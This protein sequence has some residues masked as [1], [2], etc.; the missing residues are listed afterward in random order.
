MD[1]KE[2]IKERLNVLPPQLRV[3]ILNENWRRDAEKIGKQFNF[4]EEKYAL[5]ENEIFLVLLCFEP[6]NDFKENI[7][8]ELEIDNNMAGWVDEDVEKNIFR[9]VA[10]ETKSMWQAMDTGSVEQTGASEKKEEIETEEEPQENQT[11]DTVGQ[12]FEQIIL[13][14]ARA[15]KEAVPEN[16]PGAM[17]E[18]QKEAMKVPDYSSGDPYRESTQ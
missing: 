14:Q 10:D 3:F 11:Q 4:D 2:T 1:Y 18:E 8:R 12:S 9:K 15:M 5:L 6:R 7:K 17:L 13:N 16:L